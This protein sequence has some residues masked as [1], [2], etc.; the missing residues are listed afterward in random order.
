M[1]Y[2]SLVLPLALIGLW[3]PVALFSSSSAK[4][5]LRLPTRRRRDGFGSLLLSKRNWFDLIR[6]GGCAWLIQNYVFT[7]DP[8]QDELA[9]VFTFGRL[10]IL[11]IGILAQSI[12]FSRPTCVIGPLFY[13]VGLTFAIS[14]PLVAALSVALALTCS[15]MLKRVS[16]F[17]LFAPLTL[18]AFSVLFG[19]LGLLAV[20]NAAAIALPAFLSFA[21]DVRLSLVRR[22]SS[23]A[24]RPAEKPVAAA[25]RSPHDKMIA[26][27][28]SHQASPQRAA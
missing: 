11:G 22:I 14:G 2:D 25:Q 27:P 8:R 15:L 16:H 28:I 12:W 6:A 18:A 20:F 19:H 21:L 3:M 17:F 26:A 4:E 24:P 10:A 9:L 23:A 5:E 13:V 1:N 7:F